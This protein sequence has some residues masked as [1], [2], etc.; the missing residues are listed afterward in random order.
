MVAESEWNN[1]IAE[2]VRQMLTKILAY[3]PILL[4]ALAI[5]IVC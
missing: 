3:L 2:P 4:G 1:L 5:L